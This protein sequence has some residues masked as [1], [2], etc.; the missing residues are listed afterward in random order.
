MSE[1]RKFE[2]GDASM[3]VASVSHARDI[4]LYRLFAGWLHLMGAPLRAWRKR[5]LAS[6]SDRQLA[7]AGI[8]PARAGRG[9]ASAARLDPNLEGLR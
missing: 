5:Y 6:L 7:D 4:W 1:N 9:K 8:D 2:P 3:R